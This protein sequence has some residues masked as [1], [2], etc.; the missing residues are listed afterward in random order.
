MATPCPAWPRLLPHPGSP[1]S[2]RT[3]RPL[4][5]RAHSSPAPSAEA[6]VKESPENRNAFGPPEAALGATLHVPRASKGTFGCGL[7]LHQLRASAGTGPSW[8]SSCL[9]AA[10]GD[11]H[12]PRAR[13]ALPSLGPSRHPWPR[14]AHLPGRFRAPTRS[15][16]GL[17]PGRTPAGRALPLTA[18][19]AQGPG[20]GGRPAAPQRLGGRGLRRG[21]P[22]A[23]A[24]G[25][26]LPEAGGGAGTTGLRRG[27][28]GLGA[29]QQVPAAG[30]GAE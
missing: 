27:A 24:A 2:Y 20:R 17:P 11:H 14:H 22:A 19:R 9:T 4:A 8:T 25:E 16:R 28:R 3:K 29:Q 12:R 18:R 30:E 10:S 6:A 7:L 5:H 26:Q 21:L 13:W 23:E 15:Q 1:S